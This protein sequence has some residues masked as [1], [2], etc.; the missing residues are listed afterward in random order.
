M[1]V[2]REEIL[3]RT[4]VPK[5]NR[6]R[7]IK[8]DFSNCKYLYLMAFPVILYYVLFHYLPMYGVIIAFKQYNVADGIMGSPWVGFQY[9]K[10]F[11]NSIYFTRVLKN[12][13]IISFYD[14]VIGFPF[15]IIF[16]LLMNELANE[17][18]KRF[19]QTAT[20]LPHFISLVVICGIITDYFSSSGIITSLF[21]FFGAPRINY[22]GSNA[23]FRH[24]YVWTNLWQ[25]IGWNSIVYLAALTGI[26]QQLYEAARIDGAGKFKQIIHVTLPGI[27]ST[28]IVMLIM[29]IGKVL[30]LGYEKIILLYSPATY[31][32]ADVISSFVYRRG[33]GENMQY[34]F[35]TAVGLF[36]SVVNLVLILSANAVSKKFTDMGLF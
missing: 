24:I 20:Y 15:P 36:Q 28:I 19:V 27:A 12:T 14:L 31:E 2:E 7:A 3:S 30:S 6:W 4:A 35:S 21:A 9:F 33:L 13:L 18:F 8:K 1:T 17:K 34:S 16:A 10:E 22:V 23:H 11:F 32:T 26:D 5:R 29:K 25:A